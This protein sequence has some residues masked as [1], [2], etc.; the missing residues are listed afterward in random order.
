MGSGATPRKRRRNRRRRKWRYSIYL[1]SWYKST[2]AYAEKGTTQEA[3]GKA[4]PQEKQAGGTAPATTGGQGS[5]DV[6]EVDEEEEWE[7]LSTQFTC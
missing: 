5:T 6:G 4:E 3:K 7:Y 2:N 1:L